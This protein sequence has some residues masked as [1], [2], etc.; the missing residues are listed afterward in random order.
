MVCSR[1]IFTFTFTFRFQVEYACL[2]WS[3]S[4]SSRIVPCLLLRP[5]DVSD[6]GSFSCCS[7]HPILTFSHFRPFLYLEIHFFF[8]TNYQPS[9]L[10]TLPQN[11]T[12]IR[13]PL[14]GKCLF[15]LCNLLVF[16]TVQ[17]LPRL[18]HLAQRIPKFNSRIPMM[19]DV[20]YSKTFIASI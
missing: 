18:T 3:Q 6:F 15:A 10:S 11:V 1:V 12:D 20:V 2:M 4:F 13:S 7:S 19:L 9:V 8:P 5:S 17:N 14:R 16:L